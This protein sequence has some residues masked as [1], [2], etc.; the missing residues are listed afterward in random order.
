MNYRIRY[1]TG[2]D[3][4]EAEAVMEAGSPTEAVVKFRCANLPESSAG[5]SQTITSVCPAD[6]GDVE[7][8]D[9]WR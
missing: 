4:R 7:A 5:G 9:A 2:R 6:T 8:E 1:N 3:G